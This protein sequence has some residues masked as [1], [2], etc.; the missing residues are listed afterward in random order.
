MNKK[1][2][3][4]ILIV[5]IG[6]NI[7]YTFSQSAVKFT[8]DSIIS[9]LKLFYQVNNADLEKD[10][11]ALKKD[12]ILNNL[13]ELWIS[14]LNANEKKII[15]E[16]AN[17]HVSRSLEKETTLMQFIQSIIFL[18]TKNSTNFSAWLNMLN[19]LINSQQVSSA[20][21]GQFIESVYSLI[22]DNYLLN[23]ASSKWKLKE[24]T[25]FKFI[26]SQ[27][28]NKF[29]IQF[30]AT[31]IESYSIDGDTIKVLNTQGEYDIFESHWKGKNGTITWEKYGIAASDINVK[32]SH[33]NIN[34]NKTEFH[35]DSVVY[36]NNP[37]FKEK[38]LGKITVLASKRAFTQ[39][40]TPEFTSYRNNFK[41][42]SKYPNIYFTSGIE[43]K[44]KTLNYVGTETV[45]AVAE[46]ISNGKPIIKAR[47][48]RFS[49]IDETLKSNQTDISIFIADNDSITHPNVSFSVKNEQFSFTRNLKGTGNN[50]FMNSYQMMNFTVDNIEWNIKDSLI[51]FY[52]KAGNEAMLKSTD[53]FTKEDFIKQQMYE[54]TNPLFEINK[55]TKKIGS[56]EFFSQDFASFIKKPS[57]TVNHRLME[58]WYEGF[59][60]YNPNNNYVKVKQ[61]LYDYIQYFFD[62]KDYD[63]IN[64]ISK[65]KERTKDAQLFPVSNAV[66]DIKTNQMA[67][68]GVEQIVLNERKKVGIV[69]ANQMILIG[70]NRQLFFSGRLR[71]GLADIYGKSFAFNYENY[72]IN[73][74]NADSLVYRIWDKEI[75][76]SK[77]KLSAKFLNSTIENVSG[78]V[79]I[80]IKTNKSGSKDSAQFPLFICSDTSYV[81]YDKRNK[82]GTT[83]PRERFYFKNYPFMHD[84]LLY[85]TKSQLLIPGMMFTGDI[86]PTFQDTLEV[87][88]DYSLGFIHQTPDGGF[89]LFKGKGT[90]SSEN[91]NMNSFIRLSNNGLEANGV[92]KWNNTTITTKDFTLYPDS[93]TTLADEIEIS[94][95]INTETYAEFPV[96]KGK[97]VSTSWDAV[98]DVIRYKTTGI[99]V[100]MYNEK[101]QF[102]GNFEYRPKSLTGKGRAKI[103]E[104]TVSSEDFEFNKNSF[105]SEKADIK[106]NEKNSDT[107][108]VII[109]NMKSFVDLKSDKAVFQKIENEDSYVHFVTDQ[110]LSYPNHLVW[111]TGQGKIN[112]NY[113]MSK[114]TNK[115]FSKDSILLDSTYLTDYCRFDKTLFLSSYGD[116]KFVSIKPEQDSLMF[117]GSR[118]NYYTGNK[119]IVAMDVQ[120]II[121]ADIVV[122]PNSELIINENGEMEKLLK[123]MVKARGIHN[124]SDVDIKIN[125]SKKYVASAGIYQYEDM[126][127]NLQNIN[128][129]NITYDA[130]VGAT[131]AHGFVEQYQKFNLNPWFNYYGDVNFN[132]SKDRLRFKGYARIIHSCPSIP[133]WFYFESEINPDSIYLPLESKLYSDLAS[134]KA[135]IYADVM[136]SKDSTHVFPVFLSTD[137]Y[138]NSESILSLRDSS[139][140]VTYNDN[141]NKY[142][143][144]TLAKFN[145]RSLPDAY[146]ELQRSKCIINGEGPLSLSETVK[147]NE[148]KSFGEL[149]F[150]TNSDEFTMGTLTYLDFF[151]AK[152]PLDI[153]IE[154]LILNPNLSGIPLENDSYKKPMYQIIGIETCDKMLSEMSLNAGVLKKFPKELD[155]TIVFTNL[156]FKW[157]KK[158]ISYK[159][160][161]KIGISNIGNQMINKYVNGYIQVRKRLNG[162][163]IF[164]YLETGEKEWFFFAFSGGILRTLSSVSEY[165]QV[166]SDMKTKDKKI[167]TDKGI[168]NYMLTNEETKNLFIYEFTGVHPAID[169]FNGSTEDLL[170]DEENN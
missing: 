32:L 65:G 101:V 89:P 23:K 165:N 58:L 105:L 107:K 91:N 156:A 79:K 12:S 99:A 19:Y 7:N 108:D 42:K 81:Y 113:N 124:I 135:R 20:K 83:Y 25:A 142:E 166:I 160:I 157:D 72:E 55:Y 110:Y 75:L 85:I 9:E 78:T 61:K 27:P 141:E 137:P 143:I 16:I 155:K 3:F 163:K 52:S 118:A 66:F 67:L 22:S 132:A 144:T 117:F 68:F 43:M 170:D 102:S 76:N 33:Y 47:S 49:D 53:Y 63:V 92:A 116:L 70:Q 44:G 37:A 69:P 136:S 131:V 151:F 57:T 13:A 109:K 18:K 122:T 114:F 77:E 123:T 153:L 51:H 128:F 112:L 104:G 94:E 138:G 34:M 147:V 82:Q 97:L 169:N 26:Y 35:A 40:Q 39:S 95:F 15:S 64:I 125:S 119:K 148:F 93:L 84:S 1:R 10:K 149:R 11:K 45:P 50:P 60:D 4:L 17:Y 90:L 46:Y 111:H 48:L 86:I 14:G 106:I 159:S 62:K 21:T 103:Q 8:T 88:N 150:D 162:D 152:K 126:N 140:Y 146:L 71:A 167:K 2:L 24:N 100:D 31:N 96:V 87:Q 164:I 145:N 36:I 38:I 120:K 73:T 158:S 29:S 5:L 56:D 130:A 59:L 41:I 127:K 28:E 168:F 6:F 139:F 134:N 54:T 129:D 161:G 121:V 115:L 98:N 30:P 133:Q 80:D 154:K 74:S